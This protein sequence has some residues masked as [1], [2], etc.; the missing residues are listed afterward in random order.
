MT[1]VFL[2]SPARCNSVRAGQLVTSTTSAMA[3][4]LRGPGAPLGEV[5]AYLSALYFRGK[6]T[7]AQRFATDVTGVRVMAPGLGLRDPNS[8][9]FADDLQA[10]GT[11]EVESESFI[12]PLRRDADKL[13]AR[14]GNVVLLG[15]IATGKYIKTLLEVFGE[16]LVFP[17][18]FVGRGDMSRGGL[19]LRAARD[20]NELEYVPVAGAKLKGSRP[21]KL[22][23]LQRATIDSSAD[24]SG[25]GIGVGVR[26][27][28]STKT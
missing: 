22:P 3:Q 19:L 14:P 21:P 17:S 4:R 6:L 26:V 12:R 23:K 20:G 18:S 16:R 5:F 15:S 27:A 25:D 10:M 8:V 1:T 9:I 24:R 7:Y 2:I 13:A 11:V 28:R